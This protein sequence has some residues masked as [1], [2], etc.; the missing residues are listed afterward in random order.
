MQDTPLLVNRSGVLL[1]RRVQ[2]GL[3][4]LP[5]NPFSARVVPLIIVVSSSA[6]LLFGVHVVNKVADGIK[7]QNR[8]DDDDFHV[9]LYV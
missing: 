9:S 2:A 7:C 8:C 5:V 3:P 1:Y 6:G 4:D